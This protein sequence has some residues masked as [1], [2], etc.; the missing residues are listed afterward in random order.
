MRLLFIAGTFGALIAVL[1]A[2]PLAWVAPHL[3]PKASGIKWQAAFGT[4]WRGQLVGVSSPFG[5]IDKIQINTAP[6]A[7]LTGK[8]PLRLKIISPGF[9]AQ[10]KLGW[11]QVSDVRIHG[12]LMAAALVDPRLQGLNGEIKLDIAQM[13]FA[14]DC[15][16]ASG[17]M[18][19]D[20]LQRNQDQWHW[21]GPGLSGD[22]RCEAGDVVLDINGSED[23][24]TITALFRLKFNGRYRTEIT[25]QTRQAQ[26][27]AFLPLLGFE[28]GPRGFTLTEEGVWVDNTQ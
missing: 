21:Q 13:R 9:Y 15:R 27:A 4:V 12:F 23:G 24:Q 7:M 6:A 18:S 14:S 10:G 22:V 5:P 3:I 16:A 25:L 2:L 20:V 17:T 26:A 1:G 8:A 28:D 19:S 11:N